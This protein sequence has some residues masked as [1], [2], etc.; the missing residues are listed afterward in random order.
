[1]TVDVRPGPAPLSRVWTPRGVI[2]ED[3]QGE[4]LG[5][6]LEMHS[7]AFAWWV[8][9]KSERY[10]EHELRGAADA[11]GLDGLVVKDLLALDGR[12][13]FEEI[14]SARIITT[15]VVA[16]D[17]EAVEL[18]THPVAVV[19]TDRLLI[20]LVDPTP[21]FRPA[22]LLTGHADH[23]TTGG[24]DAALRELMM[25][26]VAGYDEVATWLED[27]SDAL[28]EQLT[29]LEPLSKAGQLRAF[30]LRTVL[31]R[32]RRVTD[33]MRTVMADVTASPPVPPGKK[34]GASSQVRR[35]WLMIS[36]HHT[37]VANAVDALREAL[38]SVVATS[39]SLS[40]A[41]GNET[42]KKLSGWAAII[43]VPTL[44]SGFVG[45]NVLVPL[46]GSRAG[47]WIYLAVMVVAA[48]VLYLVFKLKRWV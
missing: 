41:Q 2:A 24:T 20:C 11:M 47:F 46:T 8:L 4:D 6:V 30:H 43:A 40:D 17:P 7:D 37:R 33:P 44:I 36:E 31:S 25:A 29:A 42:M 15:N 5:D 21:D 48:V 28:G 9:P 1:M 39:L 12:A 23:L 34:G 16:L 14:G 45:M 27:A 38:Q 26:V 3:L 13:K 19:A 18:R 35:R 32:L 22:E 10:A